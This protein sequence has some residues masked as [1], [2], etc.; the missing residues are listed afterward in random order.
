MVPS[1]IVL[2]IIML[3][4]FVNGIYSVKNWS[5]TWDENAHLSYAIR[6]VKG[7]PERVQ[8]DA[9]NSKMPISVLNALPRIVEQVL[10]P[11]I[12]KNDGG[13]EDVLSGR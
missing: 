10:N 4:Y 12:K 11:H 2:A 5:V 8:V 9:D 13:I 7:H 1:R 6:L 3:I